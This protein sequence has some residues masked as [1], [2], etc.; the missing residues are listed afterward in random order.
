MKMHIYSNILPKFAISAFS[1]AILA[2]TIDFG[3]SE[4]SSK[5]KLSTF[6]IYPVFRLNM[7]KQTSG[8]NMTETKVNRKRRLIVNES[9]CVF[10]ELTE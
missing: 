3:F 6:F 8:G 2:Y 1:F 4:L 7:T 5:Y 9:L 10:I